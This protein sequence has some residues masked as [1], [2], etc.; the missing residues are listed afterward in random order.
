[1]RL[2]SLFML[3][4]FLSVQAGWS[5][6][7]K[8]NAPSMIIPFQLTPHNN[9]VFKAVLN[10]RDTIRLMFHT[11]ASSVTVIEESVSKLQ[12]LR[13]TGADSVKSWGGAGNTSRF[14]PGNVLEIGTWKWKNVSIWENKNS[15]PETDGKFGLDLFTGK[16]L[17]LD[18]DSN[19][20]IVHDL[21]PAKSKKYE[22]L[23]IHYQDNML[24]VEASCG[25]G[26]TM[27]KNK[28]LIHSGYAGTVLLDDAFANQTRIGENLP[29]V[30]EKQ[31]KDSFGNVLKTKKAILPAF[32]VGK[33][34][35]KNVPVGFFE[36]A[37]G[38]QKMSI[39]GGDLIKR[40]NWIID[41]NRAYI[42]LKANRLARTDYIKV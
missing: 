4:V 20:L 40:F 31:L 34:Q 1:M 33:T 22:K 38:R 21:L 32:Q 26:S 11:A 30:D 18:F 28:F 39:L 2:L 6:T 9:L 24:F 27:Y 19:L 42:Y 3:W 13:F 23:P 7:P 10:Q 12:T 41:A 15:G 16:I 8:E 36:G 5:Q 25:I 29:I 37:I 35:L 14:S 17:E